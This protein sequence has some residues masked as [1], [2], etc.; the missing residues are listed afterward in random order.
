MSNS[1]SAIAID[2]KYKAFTTSVCVYL[3]GGSK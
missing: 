3:S 1:S 2:L